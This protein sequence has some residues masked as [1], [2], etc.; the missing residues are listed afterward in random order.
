MR[1]KRLLALSKHAEENVLYNFYKNNRN[2]RVTRRLVLIVIRVNSNNK[3]INS[4][5]C[6]HCLEMMKYYGIK[7]VIYSDT[8]GLLTSDIIKNMKSRASKGYRMISTIN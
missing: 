6:S 7:K 1:D 4:K 8:N 5:P 3:L 2:Y